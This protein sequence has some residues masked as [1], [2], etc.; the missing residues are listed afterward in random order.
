[1]GVLPVHEL[2][3]TREHIIHS[4]RYYNNNSISTSLPRFVLHITVKSK[5]I[6]ARVPDR[7]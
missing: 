1:M 3:N 2:W 5:S 6:T 7:R 4:E